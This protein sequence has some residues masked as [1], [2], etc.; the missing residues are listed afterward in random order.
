VLFQFL[1]IVPTLLIARG[2]RVET[3]KKP[4]ERYEAN[5]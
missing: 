4:V 5:G 2:D 3:R 1:L